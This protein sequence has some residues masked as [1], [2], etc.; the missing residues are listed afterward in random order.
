MQCAGF[1]RGSGSRRFHPAPGHRRVLLVG[2]NAT[3]SL[4]LVRGV[5]GDVRDSDGP[6]LRSRVCLGTAQRDRAVIFGDGAGAF[7]LAR[8]SRDGR[9]SSELRNADRRQSWDRAT[10]RRRPAA[11][12]YFSPEIFANNGT[13]PV[14][15]AAR[16]SG[17]RRQRCR[18]SSAR[19]SPSTGWLWTTRPPA[20][21]PGQPPDHEAGQK[22]LGLADEKGFNKF[23]AT[24]HDCR[25]SPLV[26]SRGE[27]A[28][29]A[30]SGDLVRLPAL[31]GSPWGAARENVLREAQSS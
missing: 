24:Q 25:H 20:H 6:C 14:V 27:A 22:H 2:P 1:L 29:R 8:T 10:C 19:C 12:H 21:A 9:G 11:S 7:V 26:F 30:K 16:C 3:L 23:S 28:G 4:S 31:G 17:S 5:G 15:E 18:R 13:V